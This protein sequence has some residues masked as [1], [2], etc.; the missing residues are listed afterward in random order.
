M[1]GVKISLIEHIIIQKIEKI[2]FLFFL[3]PEGIQ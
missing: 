3:C 1:K 2:Y